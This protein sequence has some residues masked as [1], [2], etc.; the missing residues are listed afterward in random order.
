VC[1]GA[2][3]LESIAGA[4]AGGGRLGLLER[5]YELPHDRLQQLPRRALA[6]VE[7]GRH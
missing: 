5:E 2:L 1:V 6:V 4:P 7:G 3:L